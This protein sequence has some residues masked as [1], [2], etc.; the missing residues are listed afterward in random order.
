MRSHCPWIRRSSASSEVFSPDCWSCPAL[1]YLYFCDPYVAF[2]DAALQLSF[3][4]R[5]IVTKLLKSAL[6]DFVRRC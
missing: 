5:L 4:G 1:H 3:L 6:S 2:R